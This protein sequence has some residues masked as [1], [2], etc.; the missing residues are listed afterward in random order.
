L[1]GVPPGDIAERLGVT[2]GVLAAAEALFFD[3]RDR[4]SQPEWIV[5][6]VIDCW[7][8]AGEIELA[9]RLKA[10]YFMGPIAAQALADPEFRLSSPEAD[11]L[12][13]PARLLHAK[14][15]A[16]LEFPLVAQRVNECIKLVYDHQLAS[17]RLKLEQRKFAYRRKRQLRRYELRR[18]RLALRGAPRDGL[19]PAAKLCPAAPEGSATENKAPEHSVSEYGGL[20]LIG[21][22]LGGLELGGLELGGLEY[23]V[24]EGPATKDLAAEAA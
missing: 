15:Q 8:K 20:E 23:S 19:A 6:V 13:D 9:I 22:E 3:V 5:R 17:R 4:L 10:A 24:P 21:L 1:G 12:V 14:L 11:L 18:Q 2:E 7:S 16:A